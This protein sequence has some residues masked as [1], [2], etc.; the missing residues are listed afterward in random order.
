MASNG[1]KQPG[2]RRQAAIA[3]LR[4]SDHCYALTLARRL[5]AIGQAKYQKDGDPR[6][7]GPGFGL[8]VNSMS[9]LFHEAVPVKFIQD[10]FQVMEETQTSGSGPLRTVEPLSPSMAA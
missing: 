6:T 2:I 3:R 5:K 10:V 9:D 1:L 7:S 8:I 4:D